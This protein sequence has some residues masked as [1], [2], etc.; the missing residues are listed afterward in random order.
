MFP[1]YYLLRVLKYTAIAKGPHVALC[2]FLISQQFKAKLLN[3]DFPYS[4]LTLSFGR[5][6]FSF[7]EPHLVCN[8]IY[9]AQIVRID[10]FI[11]CVNIYKTKPF[12]LSTG[13]AQHCWVGTDFCY[14]PAK[15]SNSF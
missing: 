9:L 15:W 6:H 5:N 8:N 3:T 12:L 2:F 13:S 7:F 10:C 14:L 4:K 1:K 11:I